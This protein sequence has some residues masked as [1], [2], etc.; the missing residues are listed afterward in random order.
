[1]KSRYWTFLVYL[2]SSPE[3]WKE[4]LS[5]RGLVFAVSP[6]HDKDVNP[7]GSQK[8]PHYHVMITWESPRS[9]KNAQDIS[10]LCSKVL[11]KRVESVRGMYRY[12]AHLDNPEKAQYNI[13]DC[14]K[15]GGFELDLTTTEVVRILKEITEDIRKLDLLEY[16]DL[17]DYY[18][19]IGDNDKW[20]LTSN[21][22]F[23]LDKYICSI[24]NK[25]KT[26]L[27]KTMK[28]VK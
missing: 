15:Y 25:K 20:E 6:L 7:D 13:E 2:D 10:D 14:E 3:N 24:R 4:L 5:E 21:H 11:P 28:V 16:S 9:F 26:T 27:Q 17:I 18:K 19:E 12:F 8:K 1:M 23:F 22:T